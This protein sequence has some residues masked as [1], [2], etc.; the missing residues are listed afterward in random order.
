[1]LLTYF[2]IGTFGN[3]NIV[4]ATVLNRYSEMSVEVIGDKTA[5][6]NFAAHATI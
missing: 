2:V 1:M 4:A 5:L 6:E 3:L